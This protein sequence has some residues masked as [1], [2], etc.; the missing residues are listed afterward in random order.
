MSRTIGCTLVLSCLI[1]TVA[2]VILAH[3]TWLVPHNFRID[4]GES[5][6]VDLNSGMNFPESEGAVTPDRIV[7]FSVHGAT[8]KR[9]VTGFKVVDKSLAATIEFEREGT[10]VVSCA[11]KP[12]T[13]ELSAEDFNEYLL[14]DGLTRIL[15]MRRRENLLE[16]DAV[17]LYSKY[18]KTIILVGGVVDDSPT[19]PVGAPI[20]L[21]PAVNP[22]GLEK[23]DDLEVSVLFHGEP[24]PGAEVAWSYPGHGEGYAGSTISDENGKATV[25][26]VQS[27]PFVIRTIQMERVLKPDYEWESVWAS[28]TFSVAE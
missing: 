5:V 28:V 27:G 12:R 4:S 21:V 10:Y 23:G 20:E 13:I 19:K 25:P 9:D 14:H 3:D 11:T 17:E 18:P 8:G 16:S 24:L 6:R 15:E 1:L 7:W 26:L 22:Y 2:A